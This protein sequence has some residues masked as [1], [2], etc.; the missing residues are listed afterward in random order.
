MGVGGSDSLG[1]PLQPRGWN[2]G[3]CVWA[4]EAIWDEVRQEFLVFWASKV[5]EEGGR[6]KP[7]SVFTLPR[8]GVFIHTKAEKYQEGMNHIIDTT[9][10]KAGE[11]YFRFSQR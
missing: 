10:L 4:P 11:Y 7:G 1:R 9:I 8:Q 2:S 3:G 6:R 5:G